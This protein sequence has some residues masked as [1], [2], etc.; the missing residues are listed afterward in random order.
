MIDEYVLINCISQIANQENMN[1]STSLDKCYNIICSYYNINKNVSHTFWQ[2]SIETFLKLK[3][4]AY[5][6]NLLK[7]YPIRYSYS[8][9]LW[10]NCIYNY[11]GISMYY[12]FI[13]FLSNFESRASD[14]EYK[15]YE[16]IF[17]IFL[18]AYSDYM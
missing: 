13:I 9:T 17:N 2:T 8:E 16:N 12:L 14:N 6:F 3:K 11:P 4:N 1:N 7:I 15:A 5:A 10:K 18:E